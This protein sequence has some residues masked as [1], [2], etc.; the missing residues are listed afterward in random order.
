MRG[1]LRKAGEQAVVA[2]GKA[3]SMRGATRR[4]WSPVRDLIAHSRK[5][6]NEGRL[7]LRLQR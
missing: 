2:S 3:D 6:Y 1:R 7:A 4:L 5:M